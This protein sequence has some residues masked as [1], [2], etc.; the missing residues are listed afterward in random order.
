MWPCI[1]RV[2]PLL[3]KTWSEL[4]TPWLHSASSAVD[5]EARR[6]CPAGQEH[7]AAAQFLHEIETESKDQFNKALLAQKQVL[8]AREM[9]LQAT[10]DAV[11]KQLDAM[12]PVRSYVHHIARF[13]ALSDR[14]AVH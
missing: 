5:A 11:V 4:S 12:A 8:T 3:L 9:Q 14:P 6:A 2:S 13:M 7:N 10:V 1:Q